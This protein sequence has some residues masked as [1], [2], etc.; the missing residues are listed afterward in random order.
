MRAY[1]YDEKI[2]KWQE[3][4]NGWHLFS[5]GCLYSPLHPPDLLC[6][7]LGHDALCQLAHPPVWHGDQSEASMGYGWPI[8]GEYCPSSDRDQALHH[9]PGV[10]MNTWLGHNYHYT[11]PRQI[12]GRPA[13]GISESAL[14]VLTFIEMNLSLTHIACIL[15]LLRT[16]AY[17]SCMVVGKQCSVISSSL[18]V[19]F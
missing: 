8:R 16:L 3:D 14:L 4:A 2:C 17:F 15:W 19:I 9:R 6:R 7:C 10:T 13:S 12:W 18:Q 5:R 11:L 1:S